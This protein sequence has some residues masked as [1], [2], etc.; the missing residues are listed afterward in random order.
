VFFPQPNFF[1]VFRAADKIVTIST[2]NQE[3]FL[4]SLFIGLLKTIVPPV[5]QIYPHC[6]DFVWKKSSVDLFCN[7]LKSYYIIQVTAVSQCPRL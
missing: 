1:F 5:F 7:G 3:A 6:K 2:T 4:E